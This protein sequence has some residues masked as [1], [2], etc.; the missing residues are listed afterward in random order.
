MMAD[1]HRDPEAT[2]PDEA[3]LS[4]KMTFLEHLE[5][6]RTRL[7]YSTIAIAVGFSVCLFFYVQ[8][9]HFILAPIKKVLPEGRKELFYLTPTE[10]FGIS[11]KASLIVGIFVASPFILW[12]LWLFIS[13][14]LYRREKTYALP[15]LLGSTILFLLGGAFAYLIALPR[16]LEFLINFNPELRPMITASEFFDFAALVILGMGVV[17]QLPVLIGFLSMFGITTPRFLWHN[18]K[19]AILII[20]IVA[21]VIS[22]TGDAVNLFVFALPMVALYVLSIGISLVFHVSRKRKARKQALTTTS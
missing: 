18:F 8:L 20:F 11:M 14:G 4:D 22:P 6:L 13:P 16:A 5:E 15:F 2:L 9:F 19:Y 10:G 17:F 21:A 3:E 7:I 12:Q 1:E